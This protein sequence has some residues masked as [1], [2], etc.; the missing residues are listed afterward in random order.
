MSKE[1]FVDHGYLGKGLRWA[2]VMRSRLFHPWETQSERER[3]GTREPSRSEQ[4]P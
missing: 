2:D 1:L 4:E 3:A